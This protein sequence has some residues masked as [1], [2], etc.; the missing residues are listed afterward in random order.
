MHSSIYGSTF[1][2]AFFKYYK[3]LVTHTNVNTRLKKLAQ[4]RPKYLT[5]FPVNSISYNCFFLARPLVYEDIQVNSMSDLFITQ[6]KLISNL[7]TGVFSSH[8][9][10]QT[11]ST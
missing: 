3:L 11:L 1:K 9:L 8:S 4:I 7:M 2:G 5:T 10:D 6:R